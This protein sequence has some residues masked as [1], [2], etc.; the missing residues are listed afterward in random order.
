MATLDSTETLESRAKVEKIKKE[1]A[2]VPTPM[3][4]LQYEGEP[5][6]LEFPVFQTF[7]EKIKP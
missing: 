3:V 5:T 4:G 7:K 1:A 6:N 2:L